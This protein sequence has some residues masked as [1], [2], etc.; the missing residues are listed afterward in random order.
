MSRHVNGNKHYTDEQAV[1]LCMYISL[2]VAHGRN[3]EDHGGGDARQ[4]ALCNCSTAGSGAEA[5]S[6]VAAANA[7]TSLAED[8]PQLS[9]FHAVAAARRA[10]SGDACTATPAKSRQQ[11]TSTAR[12]RHLSR[13]DRYV[14]RTSRCYAP[15]P[16]SLNTSF[17]R[18]CTSNCIEERL[19]AG[20]SLSKEHRGFTPVQPT[21]H[22]STTHL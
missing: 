13:E 10:A 5:P 12:T 22:L 14:Q 9:P 7:G 2:T 20:A 11:Q 16:V 18:Q 3:S 15:E 17:A 8:A 6:A 19:A 1:R 4:H 21:L